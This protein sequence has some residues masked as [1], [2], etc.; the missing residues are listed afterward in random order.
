MARI[1]RGCLSLSR[2]VEGRGDRQIL[3]CFH[4][5]GERC[6]I[7]VVLTIEEFETTFRIDM[8]VESDKMAYQPDLLREDVA[9]EHYAAVRDLLEELREEQEEVDAK[10]K[11]ENLAWLWLVAYRV[12]KKKERLLGPPNLKSPLDKC[13]YAS[14]VDSLK[15]TA[16][17]LLMANGEDKPTSSNNW[18]LLE[19]G[20][21]DLITASYSAEILTE[22]DEQRLAAIFEEAS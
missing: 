18:K 9:V 1:F 21:D 17:T 10:A 8:S 4:Q 13:A 12:F 20:L 14:I 19:A 16:R 11:I 6:R 5:M 15:H 7:I 3:H 2:A 22:S